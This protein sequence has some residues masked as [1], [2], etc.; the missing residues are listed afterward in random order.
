M[1]NLVPSPNRIANPIVFLI[2]AWAAS[3]PLLFY[4]TTT[5]TYN[6]HIL[7]YARAAPNFDDLPVRSLISPDC[8]RHFQIRS[9]WPCAFF[10]SFALHAPGFFGLAPRLRLQFQL[11]L[12]AVPVPVP[13]S[14]CVLPLSSARPA[15][16]KF[17]AKRPS[18]LSATPEAGLWS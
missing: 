11:R 5:D 1:T 8:L 3:F 4:R 7:S 12:S 17:L 16:V 10:S 13:V 6:L 18:H 15:K 9:T 2:S 14:V